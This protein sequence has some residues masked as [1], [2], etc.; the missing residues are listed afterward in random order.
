MK[1]IRYTEKRRKLKEIK[2]IIKAFKK[3][4][5][6]VNKVRTDKN[7]GIEFWEVSKSRGS[8][9]RFGFWLSPYSTLIFSW[10]PR[11]LIHRIPKKIKKEVRG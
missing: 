11:D 1:L 9:N 7:L 2:R 10:L 5:R 6:I 8:V 3:S 4:G